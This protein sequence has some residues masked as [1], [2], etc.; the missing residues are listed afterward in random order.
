MAGHYGALGSINAVR[1]I[2]R[3]ICQNPAYFDGNSYCSVAA[4]PIGA[5]PNQQDYCS[6]E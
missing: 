2:I 5:N 4:C 1:Q 3:T 6:E